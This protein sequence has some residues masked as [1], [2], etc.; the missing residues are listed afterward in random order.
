RN[1]QGAKTPRF[2]GSVLSC[3]KGPFQ[4]WCLGVLVVEKLF[5]P[6]HRTR[7]EHRPPFRKGIGEQREQTNEEP[8]CADL[9]VCPHAGRSNHPRARPPPA[10]G[11]PQRAGHVRKGE[12]S[13]T[14]TSGVREPADRVRGEPGADRP[15]GALL[16]ARPALRLLFHTWGGRTF[17][18]EAV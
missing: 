9:A 11:R 8:R 16:C 14:D 5:R 3:S 15:A 2:D 1:H 13:R 18:Y 17:F 10:R 7:V 4:A 6:A 12:P